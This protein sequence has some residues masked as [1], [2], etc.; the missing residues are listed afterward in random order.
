MPAK[1][2]SMRKLKEI[3]RLKHEG[4]MGVRAIARC[5]GLSHSTVID[6]LRRARDAALSWPLPEGVTEEVLEEKLFAKPVTPKAQ[7]PV[8]NWVYIHQERKRKGVTLELLWAEYKEAHPDGYLYSWFC[9]RYRTWNNARDLVMHLDHVPGEMLFVDYAGQRVPVADPDTGEL[10]KAHIFVA[11]LGCS[12]YTYVEA[13]WTQQLPDWTASHRRAFEFFGAVPRYV[14][15]DNLKAAVVKAHRCDPDLNPTYHDL[16]THYGVIVVPA[17]AYKA[18]DKA[19]VEKG[20]QW[21]QRGTLAPLRHQTFCGLHELNRHIRPLLTELNSKPFQKLE[22]SRRSWFEKWDRPA[23]LPLPETPYIFGAWRKA[24][25]HRDYH[26]EVTGHRY[27]VPYVH[28]RKQVDV[29]V[30]DRTVEVFLKGQRITSHLRSTRPGRFTTLEAHMPEAHR[31]YLDT[32]DLRRRIATAGPATEKL[33]TCMMQD[34][35]HPVL[36]YRS[37]RGIERLGQ[38]HGPERLE[39]ACQRAL[40]F[41]AYRYASVASILKHRLDQRPTPQDDAPSIQHA[42]IRGANYYYE[43]ITT[44]EENTHAHPSHP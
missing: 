4:E 12:N 19:K 11:T 21:A 8:P 24:K 23:M 31:Q 3:L 16:A 22:G 39:A 6:Y 42:N 35:Q 5:L 32:R 18:R 1:R 43:T 36:C 15:P 26:I 27:S 37:L 44:P 2:I 17:R 33:I 40:T 25:V 34:L 13:T 30:T 7:R 38:Q 28:A 9:E 41:G 10:R 29:R 20:V 14:V